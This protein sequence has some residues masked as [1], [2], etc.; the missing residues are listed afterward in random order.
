MTREDV[1]VKASEREIDL[2]LDMMQTVGMK[3]QPT[4]FQHSVLG[5]IPREVVENREYITRFLLLTAILDQQAKS[6]S[7]RRTARFIYEKFGESL[8]NAPQEVMLNFESLTPLKNIYKTQVAFTAIPRFGFVTLRVGGFLIYEMKLNREGRMLCRE[9]S[10]CE[11]PKEACEYL[12]SSELLKSILRE[13]ALRMYSSWVGHPDLGIDISEGWWN[14][15]D[16]PMIVNGHVGRVFSRTGIVR[17]VLREYRRP[18]II[19]AKNMRSSIEK[20]VTS[21]GYDCVMVDYGAFTIGFNCC[22]NRS[23]DA[24]CSECPRRFFCEIKDEIGC[25]GRCILSDYCKKNLRWRA[26]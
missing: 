7:A 23:E 26:Y 24:A 20:I 25:E 14:R 11:S 16:F 8:F 19:E 15:L 12:Y 21:K 4:D 10:N 22:T 2:M 9:L 5:G 13:K 17:E 18:D 1:G 3:K 6:P